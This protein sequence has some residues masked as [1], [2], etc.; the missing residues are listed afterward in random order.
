MLYFVAIRKSINTTPG[1]SGYKSGIEPC[2]ISRP[3]KP[4]NLLTFIARKFYKSKFLKQVISSQ[5][6]LLI[7]PYYSIRLDQS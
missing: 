4:K 1:I 2:Q 7:I 6:D 5:I 3:L